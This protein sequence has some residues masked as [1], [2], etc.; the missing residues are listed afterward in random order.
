MNSDFK[1]I[2]LSHG[3]N[4]FNDDKPL[5]QMLNFFGFKGD[6]D[7]SKLGVYVSESMME[8]AYFIDR[9]ARPSFHK[10]STKGEEI[11]FVHVSP[12]H[13]K[14]IKELL[15]F[16]I[17]SK[18]IKGERDLMYHFVSGYIISD[19]GLFCTITLTEQTA[20][21]LKKYASEDL[22]GKY[23]EKFIDEKDPWTG[24]TFY[25]EIGAGSDLGSIETKAEFKNGRWFLNGIKYFASNAGLADAAIVAAKPIPIKEG[26][27]GVAVFFVPAI[28]ENGQRNWRIIRLKDKLGTI[29]VPTGEIEL[30][31][32]ESY[33]LDKPENG[34][35]IALEI[36]TIARINNSLAAM[37][38]ARKAL[39]E[40]YLYSLERKTF[41]KRLIEHPLFL[42]D[43]LEMEAKLEA[44]LFLALK[45]AKM[46]SDACEEKPPYSPKYHY[47]RFMSHISKNLTA[48]ASI[49]L[50][51]YAMELMGGIGFL[52]EYPLAKIHR[53]SL[54]T[55]IWEGTTNMHALDMLEAIKKKGVLESFK[56][57]IQAAINS[58]E[59]LESK[60]IL[61]NIYNESMNEIS[62][63]LKSEKTEIHSKYI[64][65]KLGNLFAG[66]FYQS[67][68]EKIEGVSRSNLGKIFI[69]ENLLHKNPP[70]DFFKDIESIS[71]MNLR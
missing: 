6:K 8:I 26:A 18:N 19:A 50:T 30:K 13:L 47:A 59:D 57:D 69:Y 55:S 43:I 46:F 16:G 53:D 45:T 56:E 35:Y 23:L 44:Y 67:F 15:N 61:M 33:M 42:R 64:L 49:E 51:R 27:K 32:T 54:V 9:F 68:L 11:N 41:G 28:K 4:Y 66:A 70:A 14:T 65:N 3:V 62:S 17:V 24:A 21:A 12:E 2:F 31:D 25:T 36:L 71:W 37:G 60:K 40:A 20:Y 22:K 38:L 29:T 63:I 58:I 39:L 48:I 7:L 1:E 34:I 52:E 5:M 10:W